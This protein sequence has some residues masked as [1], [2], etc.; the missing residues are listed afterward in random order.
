MKKIFLIIAGIFITL[1]SNPVLA[2]A[3]PG[4]DPDVEAVPI[5]DYLW[6]LA[7]VGFLFIF[8]KVRAFILQANIPEE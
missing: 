4:D 1:I 2:Q 6:I 7:A 8:L 3:D 5:D